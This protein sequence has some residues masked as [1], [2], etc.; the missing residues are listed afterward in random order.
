MGRRL[1][2]EGRS[3]RRRSHRQEIGRGS[4][5]L[6]RYPEGL[7]TSVVALFRIRAMTAA[8]VIDSF[9]RLTATKQRAG[10]ANGRR[11]HFELAAW[12]PTMATI[13]VVGSNVPLMLS[14]EARTAER[15]YGEHTEH[16]RRED[17][18][19]QRVHWIDTRIA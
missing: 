7:Q 3:A 4:D 5:C 6:G 18:C 10:G 14:K 16:A 13:A 8:R 19:F 1:G 11:A 12:P 17:L 2:D 9:S 15:K